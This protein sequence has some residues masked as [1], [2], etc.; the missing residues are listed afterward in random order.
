MQTAWHLAVRWENV[1]VLDRLWEWSKG[2]KGRDELN[3]EFLLAEHD[4][5]MK[6]A[7]HMAVEEGHTEELE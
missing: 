5:E 3:N 6:T 2:V 1:E 4:E 7:W